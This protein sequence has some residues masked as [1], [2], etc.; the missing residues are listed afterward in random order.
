MLV[1]TINCAILLKGMMM[2]FEK[3]KNL[4]CRRVPLCWLEQDV[5]FSGP[6]SVLCH[7]SHSATSM[8]LASVDHPL[9]AEV[10]LLNHFPVRNSLCPLSPDWTALLFQ[11][12]GPLICSCRRYL[13]LVHW[14]WAP[15]ELH[16]SFSI[17]IL[18]LFS[19]I[20]FCFSRVV[21]GIE[22]N[23]HAFQFNRE[24]SDTESPGK[25][26]EK[27]MFEARS[28]KYLTLV[29]EIKHQ[30]FFGTRCYVMCSKAA[31]MISDR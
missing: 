1:S 24:Q 22:D 23:G 20:I 12:S 16:S 17:L 6:A 21:D 27:W 15:G 26:S 18:C 13:A 8:P 2:S 28:K 5:L 7:K 10:P 25:V 31:L 30:I 29:Q 19:I 9:Q 11:R 3:T 14:T 4:L